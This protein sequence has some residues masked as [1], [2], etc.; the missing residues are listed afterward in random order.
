MDEERKRD[1]QEEIKDY[2]CRGPRVFKAN[3]NIKIRMQRYKNLHP[4]KV[5]N[6]KMVDRR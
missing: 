4:D 6:I 5:L 3:G 1:P 2:N